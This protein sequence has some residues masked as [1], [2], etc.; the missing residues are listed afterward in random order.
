MLKPSSWLLIA[1]LGVAVGGCQK[2]V[3]QAANAPTSEPVVQAAADPPRAVRLAIQLI[4]AQV[5]ANT[6]PSAPRVVEP[7]RDLSDVPSAKPA[8][9]SPGDQ[10]GFRLTV[11]LCRRAESQNDPLAK[12]PECAQLLDQAN[13]QA[14]ICKQAFENG[15]DKAV[16]SE[17]CRQ[18]AGFR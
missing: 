10:P 7:S 14:R 8:P 2:A 17:G 11:P 1:C 12:T 18:A 6:T 3:A 4:A 15:D 13:E 5:P 9:P 16:L